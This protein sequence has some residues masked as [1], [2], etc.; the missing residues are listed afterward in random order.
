MT[1]KKLNKLYEYRDMDISYKYAYLA[2]TTA[3]TFF[4]LPIFPIG[5]IISFLGFVLGYFL[6]LYNFTHNYKRPEML[7]E[8]ISKSYANYFVVILFIGGI[9]DLFFFY[10]IFPSRG[11]SL[12]NFIIFLVLIFVPYTKFLKCNFIGEKEKSD[13]YPQSLSDIYFKFYNDYQRQNP[14]TKK[15]GLTNYLTALKDKGYLS[16]NAFDTA[17]A[18]IDKLNLMEIYYGIRRGN[19][20]LIHQ[21]I[22]ANTNNKSISGNNI[23]LRESLVNPNIN[24]DEEEKIKKQKYFDSQINIIFGNKYSFSNIEP[25]EEEPDKFPWDTVDE[26]GETKDRLINAYNNP[27]AINMGLGPLPMDNNIYQSIPL[28]VSK[29][30]NSDN[31]GNENQNI[32]SNNSQE[33]SVKIK[34]DI[35]NFRKKKKSEKNEL[36][37]NINDKTGSSITVQK[38]K[39]D[40]IKNNNFSLS[41]NDYDSDSKDV[42]INMP[43]KASINQSQNEKI[44]NS[45]LN[46]KSNNSLNNLSKEKKQE[47]EQNQEQ[48]N[49]GYVSSN[50]SLQNINEN[51]EKEKENSD[52]TNEINNNFENLFDIESTQKKLNENNLMFDNNTDNNLDINKINNFPM[53]E[54]S[55]NNNE[56]KN[57]FNLL[58]NDIDNISDIRIS[59]SENNEKVSSDNKD[60]PNFPNSDNDKIEMNLFKSQNSDIKYNDNNE[61][62]NEKKSEDEK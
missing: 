47:Q 49:I 17:I 45:L 6:E 23:N 4:Y 41:K 2:K 31:Y 38:S 15:L 60:I 56:N 62:D 21:S 10:E 48:E 54:I 37:N 34:N 25:I 5:F 42:N 1:Q 57:G 59:K 39:D 44:N 18:N 8:S 33:I 32:Q 24:D 53:D 61:L 20:P 16:K 14:F 40:N 43:F 55:N 52:N 36:N 22:M 7:D 50:A 26:E 35:E 30:L 28:S 11:F 12:A 51:Y 19:I 9:G 29:R 58:K 27:L 13:Y 46:K 3:M